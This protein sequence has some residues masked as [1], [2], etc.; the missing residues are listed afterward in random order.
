MNKKIIAV[1]TALMIIGIA[2][3]MVIPTGNSQPTSNHG[4]PQTDFSLT[5][6]NNQIIEGKITP[7]GDLFII[8]EQVPMST[9]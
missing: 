7:N 4:A 1:G 5:G 3:L 8:L 2:L 9:Q 6:G